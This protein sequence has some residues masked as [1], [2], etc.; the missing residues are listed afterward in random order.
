MVEQKRKIPAGLVI[1]I[2]AFGIIGGIFFAETSLKLVLRKDQGAT[3][4]DIRLTNITD[5]ITSVT[6]VT[7]KEAEGRVFYAIFGTPANKMQIA[8]DDRAKKTTNKLFKTH[9]ITI[10]NLIAETTYEFIIES[11]GKKYLNVKK[12]Y[13][14][15]TYKSG[16]LSDLSPASGRILFPNLEPAK[17]S[18]VYLEIPDSQLL[19]S[20]VNSEGRWVIPLN[21][22]YKPETKLPVK[23][24]IQ[25][26]N[27]FALSPTEETAQAVVDTG[28]D[29]PVPDIIIGK[30]FNFLASK[31]LLGAETKKPQADNI[32]I[33]QPQEKQSFSSF[34]PLIRGKGIIGESV[35]IIVESSQQSGAASVD[36]RGNWSWAPK[37]NL[38]PGEHKVTIKTRD[39]EGNQI[40]LTRR[41]FVLKSGTKILGESTPSATLAPSP[42]PSA[43]PTTVFATP[44]P[45]ISTTPPVSGNITPI[46]LLV[47]FGVFLVF[48]GIYPGTYFF[49]KRR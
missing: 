47:T 7:K 12:P 24:Q 31:D 40:S 21:I 42:S 27:I 33:I 26:I 37:N 16:K 35:S 17:N 38:L 30:K 9:H 46:I 25:T 23:K 29:S 14:F 10:R 8:Q 41:F 20:V 36:Q 15:T 43:T 19:S 28:N 3:P 11:D 22:A 5:S 39:G 44:V 32:S 4:K 45:T 34:R 18:I 13:Q 1:L 48:L 2:L 49:L 6:W